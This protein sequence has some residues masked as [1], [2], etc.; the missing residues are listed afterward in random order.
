MLLVAVQLYVLRA[1][2]RII[3]SLGLEQRKEKLLISLAVVLII[4]VNLPL[5][6][7]IIEGFSLPQLLLYSPV[8]EYE[9]VMRPFAYV[10][11]IWNF[12]SLFFAVA[13]PVQCLFCR[14]PVLRR[15][16]NP[17]KRRNHRSVR[18]ISPALFADGASGRRVNAV[19]DFCLWR[20]RGALSQ[21]RRKSRIPD[22][23]ASAATRRADHRADERHP[24]GP[25]YDR[26]QME[27]MS[28][29]P[30]ASTLTWSR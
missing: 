7:F 2:L 22:H 27:S 14:R 6:I 15:S 17:A 20:G 8:P 19:C 26:G 18:S 16:E 24:C 28:K 5:V 12:G 21:G 1:F 9:W 29:S 30:T 25:L 4:I 10:F 11:F 3:R 23:G 13:A